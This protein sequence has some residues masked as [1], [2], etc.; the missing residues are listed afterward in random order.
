M[1]LGDL[2]VVLKAGTSEFTSG[3]NKAM[4]QVDKLAKQVKRATNEMSQAGL[5][6]AAVAGGAVALASTVDRGIAKEVANLK[7][8]FTDLAV[9]VAQL[10][11]PA[12]KELAEWV[13]KLAD[14]IAGL[15]PHAKQM[16]MKFIEISAAVGAVALVVSKMAAAI[17]ALAGVF[18][19]ITAA[20]FLAVIA[21]LVTVGAAAVLLHKVWRENWGGIQEKTKQVVE[22]MS[23]YWAEFKDFLGGLFDGIID[24]YAKVAMSVVKL[25]AWL[26]EKTGKITEAQRDE[27]VK[28]LQFG[29]STAAMVAKGGGLKTAALNFGTTMKDGMVSGAQALWAEL[30]IIGK[31][32]EGMMGNS[33]KALRH[34]I[35]AFTQQEAIAARHGLMAGESG[36]AQATGSGGLNRAGDLA[37]INLAELAEAQGRLKS[38]E[39]TSKFLAAGERIAA[40]ERI[41]VEKAY[42]GSLREQLNKIASAIKESVGTVTAKAGAVGQVADAALK[43]F[44][45]G[46]AW[47]AVVAI[48]AEILTML[49]GFEKIVGSMNAFFGRWIEGIDKMIGP[50]LD[51]IINF[52]EAIG[53]LIEIFHD[54]GHASDIVGGLLWVLSK[55]IDAVEIAILFVAKA[56]ADA[57]GGNNEINK[58]YAK[59]MLDITHGYGYHE[60]ANKA[61][62][63]LN[64]VAAAA[65]K[66]ADKFGELLTNMPSGYKKLKGQQFAADAG[67]GWDGKSATGSYSSGSTTMPFSG[68]PNA[69][70]G[71]PGYIPPPTGIQINTLVIQASDLPAMQKQLQEIQKKTVKQRRR[72]GEP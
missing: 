52:A 7:N 48:I 71:Q 26:A 68:N 69:S 45:S 42:A 38:M 1:K 41:R 22:A 47:G 50:F 61:A 62:A 46:G 15:S 30:K 25:S 51:T 2:F 59:A 37:V 3:F 33:G 35:A 40:S 66:A 39:D 9:P 58:A 13:R 56:I 5:G 27:L 21:V 67:P 44:Q 19:L 54:L 65:G 23:R 17:E 16:I 49:Q 53:S 12:M 20:P 70:P 11:V 36:S 32:F 72:N 29:I 31:D 24:G 14:W 6:L 18:A 57:F 10:V 4:E 55:V 63:G 64:D 60:P 34:G 43:G 28:N 8:A